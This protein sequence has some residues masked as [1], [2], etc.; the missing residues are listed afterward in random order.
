MLKEIYIRM[1]NNIQAKN[2]YEAIKQ[3]QIKL[4]SKLEETFKINQKMGEISEWQR[5]LGNNK[6]LRLNFQS[7]VIERIRIKIKILTGYNRKNIGYADDSING[8]HI[9]E[10]T[11][12]PME[13]S[14]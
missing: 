1:E 8:K 3:L 4:H 2:I 14:K 5:T 9:Q 7:K 11:G 12:N 10:R 6:L 13:V